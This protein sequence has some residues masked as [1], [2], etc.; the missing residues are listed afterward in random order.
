M[1]Q[2]TNG[3]K[4]SFFPNTVRQIYPMVHQ[5]ENEEAAKQQAPPLSRGNSKI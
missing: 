5:S 4:K 3:E 1:R 2:N